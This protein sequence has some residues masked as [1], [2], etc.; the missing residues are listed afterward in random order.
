METGKESYDQS[1]LDSLGKRHQLFLD[2][3]NGEINV[4]LV[5]SKNDE[6]NKSEMMNKSQITPKNSS[7]QMGNNNILQPA[8]TLRNNNQN[9]S[10][11]N[12]SNNFS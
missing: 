10:I 7:F 12:E 11:E 3:P 2:S 8:K 6:E 5:L 4:Y 1:L 9:F